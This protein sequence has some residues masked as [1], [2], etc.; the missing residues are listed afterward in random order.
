[1]KQTKADIVF[2]IAS[3]I[4]GIKTLERIGGPIFYSLSI[5]LVEA[6]LTAAY[7]AGRESAAEA[8]AEGKA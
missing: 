3:T 8:A 6:A 1:M 5:S 4:L 7:E 2:R